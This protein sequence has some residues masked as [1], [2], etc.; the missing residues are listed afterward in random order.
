[1]QSDKK[2]EIVE[3]FQMKK[4]N[5][6]KSQKTSLLEVINKF[7]SEIWSLEKKYSSEL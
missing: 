2:Y 5:L 7:Y 4:R 3:S 1:M 6:L